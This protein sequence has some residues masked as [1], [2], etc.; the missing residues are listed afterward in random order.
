[1]LELLVLQLLLH[2]TNDDL[3]LK[4]KEIVLAADIVEY[5]GAVI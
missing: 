5:N 1:M 3:T 4:F 2:S